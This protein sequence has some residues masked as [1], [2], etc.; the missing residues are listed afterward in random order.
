[1]QQEEAPNNKVSKTR[2]LYDAEFYALMRKVADIILGYTT[3]KVGDP[4]RDKPWVEDWRNETVNPFYNQT[5]DGIYLELYYGMP[6]RLWT[7][8]GKWKFIGSGS[9]SWENIT[10]SLLERF[11]ATLHLPLRTDK[12]GEFG[13]VYELHKVDDTP[14][15]DPIRLNHTSYDSYEKLKV[16]WGELTRQYKSV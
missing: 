4:D 5:A 15:P 10:P 3:S 7:P 11:G 1:M 16:A 6:S 8:W 9:G 12:M 2:D 13:P 14:L